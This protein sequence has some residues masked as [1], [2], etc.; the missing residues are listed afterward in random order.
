MARDGPGGTRGALL[1]GRVNAQCVMRC[2]R[3]VVSGASRPARCWR[4]QA[5]CRE[6]GPAG[7]EDGARAGSW[8]VPFVAFVSFVALQS[9]TR[10]PAPSYFDRPTLHG[11][12]S[13]PSAV[14]FA[15]RATV[16]GPARRSTAAPDGK[17]AR[18]RPVRK[19]WRREACPLTATI[20]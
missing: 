10:P 4:R 19:R 7:M 15:L 20:C 9:I 16:C 1:C 3:L 2:A 6:E 5:G 17:P 14:S 12:V 8:R 13:A 18:A 11:N